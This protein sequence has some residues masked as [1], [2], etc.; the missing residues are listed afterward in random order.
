M[1][2][3]W[4][5][6]SLIIGAFA[7]F[8]WSID[9]VTPQGERTIYAAQCRGG[10]WVDDRCTGTLAAAERYKFRALKAKREVVYWIAGSAEPSAKL[11]EC[12][13]Q[14]GRNWS[15]KASSASPK[16]ITFE[17]KRGVAIHDPTGNAQPFHAVPKWKWFLLEYGISS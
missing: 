6:L 10:S 1:V 9:Y 2:R 13:I 17:M 14:D 8:V 12:M 7:V 4:T 16:S 11:T 5:V 3:I 15:C